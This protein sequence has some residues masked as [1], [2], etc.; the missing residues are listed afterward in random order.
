MATKKS[1]HEDGSESEVTEA[2]APTVENGE[3][4]PGPGDDLAKVWEPTR[5]ATGSEDRPSVEWAVATEDLYVNGV[6][7]HVAGDHVPLV[8]VERNGWAD[9][10]RSL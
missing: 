3:A 5:H 6:R 9:Q 2:P 4:V 1:T 8:N 10:V 7:A